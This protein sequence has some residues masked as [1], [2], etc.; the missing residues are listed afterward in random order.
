MAAGRGQGGALTPTDSQVRLRS[1][2]WFERD[3]RVVLSDWRVALLE[4]VDQTG[5][6]AAAA[7]RL[8]VPYRTAWARLRETEETL[9]FRLLDTRIGGPDGGAS[10]LTPAAREAVRRFRRVTSG[11]AEQLAD[12]FAAELPDGRF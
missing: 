5:S 7:E 3:G 11:V 6:L 2:V 4:A 1:K 8:R 12:R 9:G 10:A